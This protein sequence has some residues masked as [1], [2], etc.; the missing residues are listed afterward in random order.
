M[1]HTRLKTTYS[2]EGLFASTDTLT[3]YCHHNHST[4]RVTF[5]D[6]DGSI[7]TM[8]F[9]EWVSGNDLW[10]AVLRLM[11]PYKGEWGKELKDKV[12]YHYGKWPWEKEPENGGIV[13]ITVI[14]GRDESGQLHT[15]EIYDKHPQIID[16]LLSGLSDF[17]V[18]GLS[19]EDAT[20]S[21]SNQLKTT[22]KMSTKNYETFIKNIE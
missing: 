14:A 4:D 17:K 12:E 11:M 16:R 18:G 21:I 22:I 8:Q 13:S 7:S 5:Y 9:D 1:S 15:T 3:L 2:I 20:I 6:D 10:D 19:N